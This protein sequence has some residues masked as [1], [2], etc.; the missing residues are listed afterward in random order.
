M[1]SVK[2]FIYK[3]NQE[4]III[5]SEKIKKD[6]RLEFIKISHCDLA[7]LGTR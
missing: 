4:I 6:K 2:I 5:K 7:F 3:K 1:F